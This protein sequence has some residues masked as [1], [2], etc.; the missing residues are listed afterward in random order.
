M[1]AAKLAPSQQ[2]RANE[3]G[4]VVAA[5]WDNFL[6]VAAALAELGQIAA[7]LHCGNDDPLDEAGGVE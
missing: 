1:T 5:G 2:A 4:V 6:E 7:V 3:L